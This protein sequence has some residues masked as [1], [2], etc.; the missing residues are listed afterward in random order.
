M[1]ALTSYQLVRDGMDHIT[2]LIF[3]I[4]IN[5]MFKWVFDQFLVDSPNYIYT[6]HV[7]RY[8]LLF[9]YKSNRF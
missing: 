4:D 5:E 9:L 8:G 3:G 1:H 2:M 6:K 7:R